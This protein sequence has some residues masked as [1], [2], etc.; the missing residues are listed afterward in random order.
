MASRASC[1]TVTA[2]VEFARGITGNVSLVGGVVLGTQA[3]FMATVNRAG[4][5]PYVEVS[6]SAVES[7][8]DRATIPVL[9]RVDPTSRSAPIPSSRS[10]G[11]DADR[12]IAIGRL[13]LDG[14]FRT[15]LIRLRSGAT[16]LYLDTWMRKSADVDV[17]DHVW[18][19]LRPDDQPRVLA[20]PPQLRDALARQ[21]GVKRAWDALAPSRQREILSYLSFLRTTAAIERNVKKV[22]AE[23]LAGEARR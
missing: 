5:N 22:I 17:G 18:V 16:R 12:L 11:K 4:I 2:L 3:R 1:E 14:W 10:V 8:G 20:M 21:M 9:V 15:T 23:L 19:T 7:F 13:S 6:S